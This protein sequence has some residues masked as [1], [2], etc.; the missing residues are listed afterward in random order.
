[1]L[2]Y[3]DVAIGSPLEGVISKRC[4]APYRSGRH[5]DWLKVK[6]GRRQEVVGGG[7]T[8]LSTALHLAEKG[9]KFGLLFCW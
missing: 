9:A 6:C 2:S 1:M 8:G 7:F 3:R 5:R 4:D